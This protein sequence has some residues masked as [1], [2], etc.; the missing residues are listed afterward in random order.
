MVKN[1]FGF[2]F[3]L[4]EREQGRKKIYNK[5]SQRI[6]TVFIVVKNKSLES[7]STVTAP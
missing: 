5:L 2:C 7:F 1:G 3:N 4:N 6:T